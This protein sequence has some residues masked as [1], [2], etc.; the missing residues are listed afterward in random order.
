[1]RR[2]SFIAGTAAAAFAA[3]GI[4][5]TF[6][7][8]YP[9]KP[10]RIVVPNPPGGSADYIGR[11]FQTPLQ[12]I[13]GQPVA[14]ANVV[15]G[16]TSI[17]NRQVRDAAPDGHTVLAVHQALL[18]AAA[19]KVMDFGPEAFAKVAQVAAEYVTVVVNRKAPYQDLKSFL[20]AAKAGDLR[21]GVQIGA[22]NHFLFLS[23][24]DKTG[25]KFRFVNT[26]GGG[27]TRTALAGGHVDC[28]F[29]TVNEAKPLVDS[30]DLTIVAIFAP[31]RLPSWPNLA[32]AREQGTD[33]LLNLNYWWWMPKATPAARVDRFAEALREAMRDP[34]VVQ[35]FNEFNMSPAFLKGAELEAEINRQYEEMK[36]LAARNNVT[37]G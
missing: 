27:P 7:Q 33:L 21:A 13:L 9:D 3:P 36:A 20:A 24:A 26:G 14:V 34:E 8:A 32:T 37:A 15:G 18:T 10:I 12:R 5:P 11:F 2:R 16:G 4:A 28:A 31:Q 19:L 1:M 30:G 29:L 23:L 6:A 17:G 35:K 22:I 25:V